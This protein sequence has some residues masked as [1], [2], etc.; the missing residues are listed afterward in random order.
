MMV[1]LLQK[2]LLLLSDLVGQ[3]KES[4]AAGNI[5]VGRDDF[6]DTVSHCL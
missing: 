5:Q 1:L 6:I 4:D 2:C 3:V